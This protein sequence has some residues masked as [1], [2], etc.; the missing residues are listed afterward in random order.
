MFW[1]LLPNFNIIWT[2]LVSLHFSPRFHAIMIWN[3]NINALFILNKP[4]MG[5]YMFLYTPLLW[6]RA[7]MQVSLLTWV[8]PV[9]V[10]N[11]HSTTLLCFVF[12]TWLRTVLPMKMEATWSGRTFCRRS[13]L[14]FSTVSISSL[15]IWKHFSSRK[16]TR[17]PSSSWERVRHFTQ[18]QMN[19][20]GLQCLKT[21]TQN[22]I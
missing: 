7:N 8:C 11:M 19:T 3:N 6:F 1:T 17:Q 15:S 21:S 10:I 20:F 9:W 18:R 14:T 12:S 5:L 22:C 4:S 13:L 16:S 2:C